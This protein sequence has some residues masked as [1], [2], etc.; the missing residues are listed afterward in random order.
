MLLESN[1]ALVLI[2]EVLLLLLLLLFLPLLVGYAMGRTPLRLSASYSVSSAS[3]D[4]LKDEEEA[5]D[6][7]MSSTTGT[8]PAENILV[9]CISDDM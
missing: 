4:R 2:L 9:G 5:S 3:V 1:K 7:A 8:C 6:L